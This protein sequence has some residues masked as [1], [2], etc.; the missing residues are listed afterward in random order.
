MNKNKVLISTL[1]PGSGGVS[2]MARFLIESLIEKGYEP[3]FA[4]YEPYSISPELSVP[5]LRLMQRTIGTKSVE[6]LDGFE[7]H[8]VGA[9]LPELEFT[10]YLPT[11]PWK[12]LIRSCCYH[13][14]V[15]GNCLAGT[16]FA[17]TNT[18]FLAWVATPWHE[19]RKDRV[20]HFPLYR[21]ML[22]RAINGKVIK[23]LERKILTKGT[24]LALSEYTRKRIN[25]LAQ[26]DVAHG[27]LSMPV[28]LARFYPAAG[29]VIP[30][31]IGFVG[32]VADPRK[33]I[34]LLTQAVSIC[35]NQGYNITAE[36][37]GGEPDL[38]SKALVESLKMTDAVTFFQYLE[39]Q[40]LPDHVK[41]FDI[42]VVPSHQE[43][44]CIAAL[45][46]MA[47]GCPVIST[48][49]GGPEEF[50]INGQTGFLVNSDPVSMADAILKIVKDRDLRARLSDNARIMVEKHYNHSHAKEKF[51]GAFN[52]TFH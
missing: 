50:V 41:T 26:N 51:W 30:G 17:L 38:Q 49:C 46:A 48:F 44:L 45:E 8:A 3:V 22:D 39:N 40:V 21:K 36:I 10:H 1:S 5:S 11:R 33:N 47:C 15:S 25:T 13:I 24:I 34:S 31:R 32:R 4:Y 42:F 23:A 6:V 29:D 12:Q 28:D 16:P 7:A 20:R 37:I 35:K 52:S 14:S 9:W 19:D 27:V 2:R 43:G 18:Q